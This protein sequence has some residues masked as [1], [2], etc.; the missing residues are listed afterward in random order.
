MYSSRGLS[1]GNILDVVDVIVV[2]KA[3][4]WGIFV[5]AATLPSDEFRVWEF[6]T[7]HFY[8]DA[9]ALTI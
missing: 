5:S 1:D 4:I 2:E 8:I 7:R 6:L 3:E 9:I